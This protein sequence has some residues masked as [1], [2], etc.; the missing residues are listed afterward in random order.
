[1]CW[2]NSVV[3]SEEKCS[4][5]DA[6][7]WKVFPVILLALY[8]CMPTVLCVWFIMLLVGGRCQ[9]FVL[10]NICPTNLKKTEFNAA[11]SFRW[12]KWRHTNTNRA[13]QVP[14]T[15]TQ[16]HK[17]TTAFSLWFSFIN[18]HKCQLGAN[19][20]YIFRAK[21]RQLWQSIKIGQ[22]TQKWSEF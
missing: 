5:R 17:H 1:M 9:F 4:C 14:N 10:F 7:Y 6:L 12:A 2:L 11:Q 18:H 19:Y 15:D 22:Q 16:A 13:P 3:I 8:N 20:S 21:I